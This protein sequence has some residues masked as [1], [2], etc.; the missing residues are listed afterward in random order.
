MGFGLSV[1]TAPTVEPVSLVEAKAHLRVTHNT[2][3][4]YIKTL[5]SAARMHAEEVTRRCFVTQT[6]TLTY[7]SFPAWTI[8]FPRNPVQS[9]TSIAYLDN[10][11]NSQT[12]NAANYRLDAQTLPARVTPIYGETWPT[13]YPT[14]AAVTVTFVAGY[15]LSTT[16]PD[17]I[18]QAIL[19]TVGTY[20]DSVRENVVLEGS[21]VEVPQSAQWLLG[22]YCVP[23]VAG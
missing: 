5:I 15:G 11:G 9:I 7:D 17:P 22:P 16:V 23:E 3:D 10:N 4:Q 8:R 1:A 12:L 2:D 19:L 20:Y 18:K 14:T 13:T 6:L 21:P